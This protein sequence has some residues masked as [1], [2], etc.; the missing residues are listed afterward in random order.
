MALPRSI[1][2]LTP[3]RVRD[4]PGLRALALAVGLI[5]PR[6]M[7]TA[8]EAARLA[9]WGSGGRCA[10]EIGVYEGSSTAVLCDALGPGAELHLIDPFTDESGWAMRPGWHGTRRAT[11]LAVARMARGGPG[12]RWHIARS[13]AVGRDWRGPPVDFLFI[14]GDHSPLGC[15]EDWEVW[16]PHVRLGGAV[17]F[18]DAR[19]GQPGGGGS[20][21]PTSVVDE[22]FRSGEPPSG[23]ELV[24]E[25]DSLVVTR[26]TA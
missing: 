17:A 21:G 8:A 13:Q 25:V 19:L 20:P 2:H 7:H 4:Q 9:H 11:Q 3:D 14:D 6:T 1:R 16:H 22:L 26:R 5:P 12:V 18:H 10:V 24:D 15:A 23:W